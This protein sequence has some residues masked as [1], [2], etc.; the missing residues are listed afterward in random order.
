MKHL[1]TLLAALLAPLVLYA[2]P[3]AAVAP[4]DDSPVIQL[5]PSKPANVAKFDAEA[6]KAKSY[7]YHVTMVKAPEAWAKNPAAKGKGFKMAIV[8][9]WGQPDHPG[10]DG[11]VK[12]TYSAITKRE[13]PPRP[14]RPNPHC[15][16]CAGI[17]HMIAP[18][19]ELYLI[20]GMDSSGRGTTANLAHGIDYA[21][22]VFKVD[23]VSCSFGG[24]TT[25]PFLPAAIKRACDAG[26][27]VVCAAGN[28]G[29]GPGRDTEG[30]PA[31]Y[32]G[33]TSVAACDD[34]RQ[35]AGF[36]SWGP[37]VYTTKPGVNIYSFL[38]DNQAGE[39]DG[40]SMACPNEAGCALSWVASNA[41]PKDKDRWK[42]YREAVL[43]ASPFDTRNN[44]RG[45]GLY[46]IDKITGEANTTPTPPTPPTPTPGEKVYTLS[47]A[48]L[49]RQG[50]TSVRIDLGAGATSTQPIPVASLPVLAPQPAPGVVYGQPVP[51]WNG[52]NPAPQYAPPPPVYTQ[53]PSQCGPGGCQSAPRLF[54]RLFR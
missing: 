20:E 35:L 26:V 25:D 37:T 28:D 50:Y 31:R 45:Y 3:E 34:K 38:P 15:T 21:V 30:Y 39:M 4:K 8:D 10:F 17:A 43:K 12:G 32:T 18:E 11:M 6:M 49:Q 16:H 47:L 42:R 53:M 24:P 23:V 54:H 5:P 33:A 40:T 13:N 46:T 19:A 52:F 41:D 2:Q 14:A 9:T 48:D 51:T 44:A 36:S 1:L 22:S 7:P 29:G 27:I